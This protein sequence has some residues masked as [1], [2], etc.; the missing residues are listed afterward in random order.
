M[1]IASRWFHF[2]GTK[3]NLRSD[4]GNLV[5]TPGKGKDISPTPRS[6]FW[7]APSLLLL[8]ISAGIKRPEHKVGNPPSSRA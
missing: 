5:L 7:D 6:W 8:G 3:L 4:L 1:K 2:T